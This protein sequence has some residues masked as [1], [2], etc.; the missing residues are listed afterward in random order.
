MTE[1]P[2]SDEAR[3]H[4]DPARP[5]LLTACALVTIEAVALFG[6]AITEIAST[7]SERIGLGVSTA[8]FFV[9]IGLGLGVAA[10]GLWRRIRWA[11]GPVVFVQLIQLGLAWNVRDEQ[12]IAVVLLAVAVVV[13]AAVLA[14]AA[15]AA[16]TDDHDLSA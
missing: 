1:N 2:A 16:L 15:T 6:I 14:P 13:L 7:S 10:Y 11:R 3:E 9:L 4:H 8:V 5:Y 12:L